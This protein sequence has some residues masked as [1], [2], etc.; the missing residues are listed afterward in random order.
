MQTARKP[1]GRSHIQIP[2]PFSPCLLCCATEPDHTALKLPRSATSQLSLS[3]C[4]GTP[5]PARPAPQHPPHHSSLLNEKSPPPQTHVFPHRCSCLSPGFP[6]N[7][8]APLSLIHHLATSPYLHLLRNETFPFVLPN[9]HVISIFL[10]SAFF[11]SKSPY[12]HGSSHCPVQFQKEDSLFLLALLQWFSKCGP[13]TGRQRQ[14]H[15]GMC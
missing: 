8:N 14:P 12:P 2:P 7:G 10:S 9:L 6:Y 11:S 5:L 4:S 15:P 1:R 13:W 3:L